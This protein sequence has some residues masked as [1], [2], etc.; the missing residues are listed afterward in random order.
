MLVG[1]VASLVI[2]ALTL[3][4]INRFQARLEVLAT[5]DALTGVANRRMLEIEFSRFLSVQQRSRH[6]FSLILVDLDGFKKVNDVLGHMSGD[7]VLRQ[8][9]DISAGT[10]RPI[11]VVARWGGDEFVVL[12]R[13]GTAEAV[14]V[15][16]RLADAVA[17]A[18]LAGAGTRMDD[19][20]KEITISCGITEYVQGDDLD[21]MI[22]RAD[23][24]MYTSKR[25][26]GNR[27]SVLAAAG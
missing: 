4:T 3:F 5:I 7:M 6:P 21:S 17:A 27:V 2:I 13:L 23:Q 19:P 1:L 10:V 12:T 24:A 25:E 26:G 9:A 18:D 15:A 14:M 20:R 11:D 22:T 16:R 8:I